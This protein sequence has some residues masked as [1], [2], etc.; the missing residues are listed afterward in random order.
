MGKYLVIKMI[1][2]AIRR[3]RAVLEVTHTAG[4]TQHCSDVT[5]TH[6]T[7]ANRAARGLLPSAPGPPAPQCLLAA[8]RT[9][10][11]LRCPRDATARSSPEPAG[12]EHSKGGRAW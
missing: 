12:N 7:E 3:T 6:R 10:C 9:G 8:A 2:R 1:S 11:L 5:S 4:T